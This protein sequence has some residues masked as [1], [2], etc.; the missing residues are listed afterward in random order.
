M[1]DGEDSALTSD[2]P[3]LHACAQF[4][5]ERVLKCFLSLAGELPPNITELVAAKL[6]ACD[7]ASFS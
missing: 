1:A 3:L 7:D 5:R 2:T 6:N 4:D